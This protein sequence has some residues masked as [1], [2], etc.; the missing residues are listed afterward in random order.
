MLDDVCIALI[1]A[2]STQDSVLQSRFF[3]DGLL[4]AVYFC[5]DFQLVT[6]G[7]NDA[8]NKQIFH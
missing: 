8:E 1:S 4:T 6:L 5:V 3:I 2:V 7:I